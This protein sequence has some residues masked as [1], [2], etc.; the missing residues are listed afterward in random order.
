MLV[1]QKTL[2]KTFACVTWI[3]MSI[4]S[5]QTAQNEQKHLKWPL[6]KMNTYLFTFQHNLVLCPFLQ[7]VHKCN[8]KVENNYSLLAQGWFEWSDL[9]WLENKLKSNFTVFCAQQNEKHTSA[10][11]WFDNTNENY[12]YIHAPPWSACRGVCESVC[13]VRMRI[14]SGSSSV[15]QLPES[16]TSPSG[17]PFC[18]QLKLNEQ[19][20]THS[21]THT[22][23]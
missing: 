22:Q 8:F 14:T 7:V 17:K 15:K 18:S 2:Q 13:D 23:R 3:V 10:D 16:T 21:H 11:L 20:K 6:L 1:L 9:V 5:T 12:V 19:L 4:I